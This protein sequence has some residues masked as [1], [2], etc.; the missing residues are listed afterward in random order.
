MTPT[1]GQTIDEARRVQRQDGPVIKPLAMRARPGRAAFPRLR[2]GQ[3]SEVARLMTT[4][5]Q[6]TSGCRRCGW[7]A[8]TAPSGQPT[9]RGRPGLAEGLV[10]GHPARQHPSGVRPG[11]HFDT[12][13][14]LGREPDLNASPMT[15]SAMI[16]LDGVPIHKE[17][18]IGQRRGGCAAP[19][20]DQPRRLLVAGCS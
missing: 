9:S 16:S 12:E 7:R 8:R 3:R 6:D 18:T 1:R 11:Q 15:S 20:Q 10:R 19:T 5:R 2:A 4:P 17:A 14:R 13:L